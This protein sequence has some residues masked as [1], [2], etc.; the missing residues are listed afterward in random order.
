MKRKRRNQ[1]KTK[2]QHKKSSEQ[3]LEQLKSNCA[4]AAFASA[5]VKKTNH[6][7]AADA[8]Q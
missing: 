6:I 1:K 8:S 7:L 5:L 4:A 2:V 3:K